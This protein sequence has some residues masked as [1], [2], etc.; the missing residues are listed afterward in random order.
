MMIGY[1]AEGLEGWVFPFRIFHDYRVGFRTGDSTDVVPGSALVRDVRVNPES[2]TRVYS[3]QEFTARETLFVPLDSAGFEILYQ[4]ESRSPVHIV[5][6]FQPDLNL[7]WPG[8]IGGQKHEWN[9]PPPAFGPPA[10]FGKNSAPV[11]S[12]QAGDHPQPHSPPPA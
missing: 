11:G 1:A 3:G 7:M 9:A 6:S 12:P 4:V 2:V 8:G 5:L 10:S